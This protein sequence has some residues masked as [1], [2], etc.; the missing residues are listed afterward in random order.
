M[1]QATCAVVSVYES[2]KGA[3][4]VLGP[5]A[6]GAL[7]AVEGAAAGGHPPSCCI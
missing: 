6:V 1:S 4:V 2:M 5:L 3:L 7:A